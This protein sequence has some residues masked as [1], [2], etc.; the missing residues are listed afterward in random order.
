MHA[1]QPTL[2]ING[3]EPAVKEQPGSTR[4]LTVH[5]RKGCTRVV[6]YRVDEH[7]KVRQFERLRFRMINMIECSRNDQLEFLGLST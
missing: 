6:E 4:A 7:L 3:C 1:R 5:Q 2:R